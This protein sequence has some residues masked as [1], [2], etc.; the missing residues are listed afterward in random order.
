MTSYSYTTIDDPFAAAAG[1]DTSND[2]ITLT[3]VALSQLRASDSF[4]V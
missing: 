4:F 1:G 3:G 2:T